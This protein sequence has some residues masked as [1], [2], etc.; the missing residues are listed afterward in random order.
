L[1]PGEP[2]PDGNFAIWSVS[3]QG[4]PERSQGA[5]ALRTQWTTNASSANAPIAVFVR[6]SDGKQVIKSWHA[7]LRSAGG[8]TGVQEVTINGVAQN[9]KS[10]ISLEALEWTFPL[11]EGTRSSGVMAGVQ[12]EADEWLRWPD[13]AR[14]VAG[15][16]DVQPG[17]SPE[18]AG[19]SGELA[20]RIQTREKLRGRL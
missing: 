13:A 20:Q 3:G 17:I 4:S 8:V 19:G 10:V 18:L 12:H 5:Q 14:R 9:P 11:L 1:L 15:H 2:T 7:Q 16:C 6:A